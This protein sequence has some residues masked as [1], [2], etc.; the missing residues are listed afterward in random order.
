MTSEAELF[1]LRPGP[2]PGQSRT[3]AGFQRSDAESTRP[4]PVDRGAD[5]IMSNKPNSLLLRAQ[6]EGRDAK[7]TQ[8]AP[9]EADPHCPKRACAKQTQFAGARAGSVAA[10]NVKRSQFGPAEGG[11]GEIRSSKSR[12]DPVAGRWA[13]KCKTKPICQPCRPRTRDRSRQTHLRHHEIVFPFAKGTYGLA[14]GSWHYV[15]FSG[16]VVHRGSWFVL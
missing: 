12:R 2:H 9:A 7:R 4:G 16:S 13:A 3:D 15:W 8:S 5:P 1:H 10:G 11:K 14:S 6:N